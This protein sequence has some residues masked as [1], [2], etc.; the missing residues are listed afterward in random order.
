LRSLSSSKGSGRISHKQPKRDPYGR[1]ARPVDQ[2]RAN[3]GGAAPKTIARRSLFRYYIPDLRRSTIVVES[4]LI[5]RDTVFVAGGQPSVTYVEREQLHIERNLARALAA[6]NQI[7]SL[8]GPTKCGKTVLCRRMLGSRE[9]VW[10]DG[11]QLK[12]A[13]K[14]WERACYELNYPFEISKSLTD[15]TNFKGGLNSIIA[16]ASGSR[17]SARESSRTYKI[18]SMATAIRHMI[19]H[20]IVLVVDDFHYLSEDVR[21][22]FLR[23]IKG[24]VFN[25]LKVLLLSITHRAFD[26]IKSET[27]LTGRFTAITV[28][29]WSIEDLRKIPDKGF[30]ALNVSCGDMLVSGLATEAQESPFLMQK[31]CWEICFDIGVSDRP[32][33]TVKVP[34]NYDLKELYCR[35]AVDSGLPIYQKL[36]AG[37][38]ARKQRLKRP[39]RTG[40]EADVYEATLLAIAETGPKSVLTYDEIRSG[41]TNI[42]A[43]KIPQKHE[44]TSAFKHLSRISSEQGTE[45]GLDWDESKRMLHVTDPY[46]RFYLRWQVRRVN[47]SGLF[48]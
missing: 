21:L 24:A 43:D 11:G 9:Y 44:V 42:L 22:E 5:K 13:D 20:Q 31:F 18:D 29:E 2:R 33:T 10:L 40:N 45:A 34:D 27:E 14:I 23:N 8:A 30:R 41:L 36:V 4:G 7:A 19:E 39:L 37:P 32:N 26:P 35:I 12:S 3:L 47:A 28:P 6:P 16:T 48:Q 17:L 1:A 46:L 38:Q 15:T 25:G